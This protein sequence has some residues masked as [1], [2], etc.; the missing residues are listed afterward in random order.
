MAIESW[1]EKLQSQPE[2]ILREL[3]HE[4]AKRWCEDKIADAKHIMIA[5]MMVNIRRYF[6]ILPYDTQI[7]AFLALL[8]EESSQS[9]RR[10]AQIKA[11]E[12]NQQYLPC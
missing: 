11:G 4:N 10:I 12:G 3:F 7:I 8:H 5:I 2:M 1:F 9:N 6:K